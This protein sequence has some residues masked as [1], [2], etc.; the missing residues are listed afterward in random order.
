[1][2]EPID[3]KEFISMMQDFNEEIDQ[4]Y[5]K[6]YKGQEKLANNTVMGFSKLFV[7]KRGQDRLDKRLMDKEAWNDV[8][9]R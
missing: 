5:R 4:K 7:K 8:S 2:D 6:L 1:M 9:S 3:S